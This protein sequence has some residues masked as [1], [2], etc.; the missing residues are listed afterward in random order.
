M[1]IG[2]L[3]RRAA[4]RFGDRPAVIGPDGGRS[5]TE[6]VDRADRLA[7][8]LLA[9]GLR[10]GE[11]VME[12]LPN[13]CALVESD[14]ALALAGL[15]RV[16]LNPRL[17]PREWER[18]AD[19]C[20]AG[21][22]IYDGRYTEETEALRSGLGAARTVVLGEGPGQPWTRLHDTAPAG[23]LR[24]G[25]VD[26]LAGLAYSSGT[27]GHPKGARRTHRNRIA[28]ALAM[29][30]EVLGGP[31][32]RDSVYL[33]AGP[34]IHTSGLF[35]LPFL[36]A[37]ALQAMLDHADAE[38]ILHAIDEYQVTHI[39]LVPTMVDRLAHA[40]TA[41]P[42][43]LRMLA[44]AGS[45]MPVEHIR[46]ASE[47]L[48]PR[49]VQYYGLVEAMPPLTVLDEDDHARGLAGRPELLA[50][51][52][53]ICPAVDLRVAGEDGRPVPEGETGEVLVSGDP[54]TTGYFNAAD[55]DDL[56]KS[57]IDG[58]LR[59]G[60][61]GR[62]GPGGRLWLTD[63]RNDM[64]ITGGYN[65]YP[66]EVEEAITCLPGIASAAVV[67][68]PDERWGQRITA[69]YSCLPDHEI[70]PSQ[71]LTHCRDRLPSHKRPKS[72]HRVTDLPL[73]ATGK[74]H[75]REIARRLMNAECW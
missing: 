38:Q 51:A 8:A 49:L 48:T 27:T 34:A 71:L 4:A 36:M 5:F 26:D 67:G 69:V 12:L 31:P 16:P 45:P 24:L 55:R 10:P 72:A 11:R 52:G 46:R 65:V 19:D 14:L 75:R 50:S 30:H 56:G 7:R 37:G 42:S 70:E 74:I 18:M 3:A 54:V 60:D 57:F 39:A 63:R 61:V 32:A 13:G 23:P 25:H 62:L 66:R 53:R 73:N 1:T 28:S 59:T 64:I 41:P 22:L 58:Y 15:V 40:A 20:G 68:L 17:G 35:V 21:A 33:H 29:T 6:L 2:L 44:Y 43:S 9:L 47:R